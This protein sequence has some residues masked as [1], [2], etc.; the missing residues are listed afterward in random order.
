MTARGQARA[1]RPCIT[2]MI[3]Y[4]LHA[5]LEAA[6]LGDID[7]ALVVG[8]SA[9]AQVAGAPEELL[10]DGM[11]WDALRA[12]TLQAL[13]RSFRTTAFPVLLAAGVR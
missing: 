11:H 7:A 9:M 4:E 8:G 6:A 1:R 3:E 12:S 10:R 2:Q 5:L 13:V